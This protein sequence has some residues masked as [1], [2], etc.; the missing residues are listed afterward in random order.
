MVAVD[1][2]DGAGLGAHDEGVRRRPT[3]LVTNAVEQLTVGDTGG[4]EE[5]VVAADQVVGREHPAE[6][7]AGVARPGALL[8]VLRP[9]LALDHAAEALHR[10]GGD[11][12]FGSAADAE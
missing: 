1:V 7:M 11:D 9:Q 2:P 5:D 12:A 8:V 10:A 6:V 3:R 4:D